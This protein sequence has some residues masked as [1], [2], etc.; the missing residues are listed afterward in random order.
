VAG[1]ADCAESYDRGTLVTLTAHPDAATSDFAGFSGGGCSGT[2]ECTVT[3]TTAT[4]VNA[5]FAA[6]PAPPAPEIEITGLKRDR[7]AGTATLTVAHNLP[8]D[9]GIAT[10][11]RVKAFGPVTL[12]GPGSAEL[13][14]V[15]RKRA[16][17]RLARTGRVTVNPRIL[18]ES[19]ASEIRIRHQFD[20]LQR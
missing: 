1:H 7:E 8:G 2:E 6:N 20:L 16:A 13:E 15:L 5:T 9:L 3:L 17:K 10:S 19:G 4:S 14:I 18:F 12:T 11:I